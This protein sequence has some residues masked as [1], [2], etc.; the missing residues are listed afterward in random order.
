M[1]NIFGED[2]E[3]MNVGGGYGGGGSWCIIIVFFVIAWLLFRDGHR[4]GRDGGYAM[5]YPGFGGGC[6]CGPCVQPT[7]KDESNWEQEYHLCKEIGKVDMD[8]W[9]TSCET[10]K[11]VLCDGQKTR[12]LIEANYIQDLRDKLAEKNSEVQT[13]K[14]EM[15]TERKIDQVLGAI[16]SVRNDVDK[17]FCRTDAE[18]AKLSCELP[19]RPP[20]FSRCDVPC[21]TRVPDNCCEDRFERFEREFPR[22]GRCDGFGFDGCCA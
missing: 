8:V 4:D 20:V 15:F 11:E 12:S 22:R 16:G 9:K 6:G 1:S 18:I 17:Q 3:I 7:F 5:P 21:L 19:K 2:R 10:Q 13:L 14:S